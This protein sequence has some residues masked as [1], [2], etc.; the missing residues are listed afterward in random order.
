MIFQVLF[1]DQ[2]LCNNC[3]FKHDPLLECPGLT[4]VPPSPRCL[5]CEICHFTDEC[6]TPCTSSLPCLHK[7][8]STAAWLC[9]DCLHENRERIPDDTPSP[10]PRKF[11]SLHIAFLLI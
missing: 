2:P 9:K 11:H 7:S 1:A 8:L 3:H 6:P 4:P 5:H 10:T